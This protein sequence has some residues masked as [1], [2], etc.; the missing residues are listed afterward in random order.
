[1]GDSVKIEGISFDTR[2][3]KSGELFVAI[4]GEKEDGH[5]YIS[6]AVSQGASGIVCTKRGRSL[7]PSG[8]P[9]W[10]VDD[11]RAVLGWLAA[12][13]YDYPS[14]HLQLIGV[15]GTNGKTTVATFLCQLLNTL[16]ESAGLLS[17]L[18]YYTG[19]QRIQGIRTTPDAVSIQC[20]LAEMLRSGS[21]YAVVEVSSHAIAQQRI[22]GLTF[23]GG[24]FTNVTH[25]HLDYHGDFLSYIK[26]KKRFFDG[27]PTS[28]FALVNADDTQ[29]KYMLQNCVSA[30]QRTYSC[31]RE[32]DYK[33]RIVEDEPFGLT[34]SLQ[35]QLVS[36]SLLGRF[37]AYNIL[38]VLG[39]AHLLGVDWV[40]AQEIL[41]GFAPL[42]G[43]FERIPNK[44]GVYVVIDYA[45][46]PDALEKVLGDL[47]GWAKR[48]Q[49][50]ILSVVGCGGNRDKTKRPLMGKI[51]CR[52]SDVS[53][54]TS[55]NPRDEDPATILSEMKELLGASD[56]ARMRSIIDRQEAISLA[57]SEAK[58][59]DILLVTGKG[60]E[61][62]QEVAG[63]F[64]KYSDKKVLEDLTQI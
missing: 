37:N 3:L 29:G 5:Q 24:I 34:L 27:L 61:A 1:M 45:H 23:A 51:A 62:Y 42:P 6:R 19:R 13:Y 59:G 28:S 12:S 47:F 53:F 48:S 63:K 64:Y 44:R 22:Q 16:G 41:S 39:A 20:Y 57:W 35:D 10:I 17:T 38:A 4:E 50:R 18:E 33:A 36:F 7:I 8:V 9:F 21:T 30:R 14:R 60:H 52:Y 58:E 56:R 49:C 54:F 32:S 15:T 31:L 40:E 11:S 26:E 46:T 25:D 2:T 43:R 55:D